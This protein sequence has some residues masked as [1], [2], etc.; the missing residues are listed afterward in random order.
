MNRPRLQHVCING[1]RCAFIAAGEGPSLVLLHGWGASLNLMWPLAEQLAAA[2]FRVYAPDLPG[3]GSSEAPSTAWSVGDYAAFVTAFLDSQELQRVDL[4]GHSFG[5]RICLKLG[6]DSP[7]RI[8]RLLLFNAAGL[9]R[10][11]ILTSRLR[12]GLFRCM[13]AVL[14]GLR[15]NALAEGLGEWYHER[16]ASADYKMASGV[17]KP[18]F[19]RVVNEDLRPYAA[20]IRPPALIFWGDRDEETPLWMGKE[21]E[22]LIPDAGLVIQ[23]DAG[24]Y[25]YLERLADTARVISYFLREAN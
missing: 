16:Y 7:E 3:F 24:H 13:R 14:R 10:Q 6:A 2:G 8:R 4:G 15:L 1:L 18:T 21:L 12:P 25:S 9:R 17:M 5:G 19:V 23:E 20:R 22:R 11:S